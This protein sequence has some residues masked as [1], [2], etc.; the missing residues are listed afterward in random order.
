M[1]L[2]LKVAIEEVPQGWR[3]FTEQVLTSRKCSQPQ[4]QQ[5]SIKLVTGYCQKGCQNLD[6]LV[7]FSTLAPDL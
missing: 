2:G 5:L 3:G 4:E 6:I 7:I 1:C